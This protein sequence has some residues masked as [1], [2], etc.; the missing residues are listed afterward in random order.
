LPFS[1]HLLDVLKFN[2]SGKT[3][4][5]LTYRGFNNLLD[6]LVV[7]ALLFRT[8][9]STYTGTVALLNRNI[10]KDQLDDI[11]MRLDLWESNENRSI[12]VYCE[13]A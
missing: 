12:A 10:Q 4:T 8:S 7:V 3:T 6:K 2:I 13:L 11:Y 5:I 1:S 9:G